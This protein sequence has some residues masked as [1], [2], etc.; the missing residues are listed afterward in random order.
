M[1]LRSIQYPE[2]KQFLEKHWAIAFQEGSVKHVYFIAETKG[3]MSSMD[4]RK[5]EEVKIECARKF[6]KKITSEQVVYDHI[7]SYESLMR[8]VK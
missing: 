8:L 4:L 7:D 3:S 5:V 6:F 2:P 1:L